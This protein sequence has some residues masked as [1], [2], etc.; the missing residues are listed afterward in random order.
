[1]KK[2]FLYDTTLR[3]GS[4]AEGISFSVTDKLLIVQKL[5]SLGVPYVEGGWPGSNPKDI[6]FFQKVRK[7]SLN[8]SKIAAFGSTRRTKTDPSKDNNLRKLLES[9]TPVVTIFGKSSM[10]HVSEILRTT[11]EENLNMISDS[12][13][14]LKD[15]GRE[16]VYDAE[17]F[18]DGYKDDPEYALSSLQ[19]AAKSGAD[20]IV[21]CDTN[22]G[23]MPSEVTK[24]T[25]EVHKKIKIP[26]GIHAH[27][28]SECAVANSMAAV[29][30]GA[31]QIQGTING[32]GERCG[33]ANL[34]SVIPNLILISS[35][36]RHSNIL[37]ATPEWL[38]IPTPTIE[39]LA[40][41]SS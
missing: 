22:G 16:C 14:Y 31:T 28:D 25:Q 12:L 4:Q 3:D 37:A 2:V 26:L 10:F 27:N 36:D 35:S 32:Y 9:E 41:F 40:I 24:I 5:D 30:A 8:N 1:M 7:L 18:F 11:G 13:R 15:H 21:L 20:W 38:F 17:H 34:C 19:A 29:E 33:N 6:E 23:T 39:I